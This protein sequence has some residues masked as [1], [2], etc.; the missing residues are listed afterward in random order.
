MKLKT[1]GRAEHRTLS[2]AVIKALKDVADAYGVSFD[3]A[4][5]TIGDRDGI[6]RLGVTLL[7]AGGTGMSGAQQTFNLH[8]G[9]FGLTPAHFGSRFTISGEVYEIT[10]LNLN[11]PK[12]PIQGKRVRDGKSFKF[13]AS[14]V[15][16]SVLKKAA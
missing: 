6:I 8:C 4:G 5:G 1:F 9:F 3:I 7:D 16:R 15:Q 10:G 14:T 11:A 13:P 2:D 12:Y